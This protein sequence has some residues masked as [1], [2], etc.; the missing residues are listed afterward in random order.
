MLKVGVVGVGGISGAHIPAWEEIKE[1]ELK[2]PVILV[3]ARF[4]KPLDEVLLEKLLTYDCDWLSFEENM[5]CGGLGD[6]LLAYCA[7]KG[8]TKRVHCCGIEDHFVKQGAMSILR[9]NEKVSKA[10]LL[11]KIKELID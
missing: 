7:S 5:L 2:L 8:V 11:D 10:A 4:L 3:N 6:A 1:V 9:D